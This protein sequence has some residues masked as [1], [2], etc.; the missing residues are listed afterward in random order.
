MGTDFGVLV[1]KEVNKNQQRSMD[2]IVFLGHNDKMDSSFAKNIYDILN[3]RATDVLTYEA[4]KR[5]IDRTDGEIISSGYG[6]T[7]NRNLKI[8]ISR[9]ASPTRK[10]IRNDHITSDSHNTEFICYDKKYLKEKELVDGDIYNVE[11]IQLLQDYL[12]GFKSEY[13]EHFKIEEERRAL[14][15]S[16][17]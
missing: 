12:K 6:I 8:S 4:I 10:L 13:P 11:M 15:K 17:H 1:K 5:I 16:N 3:R 7:I 9:P 2:G 14:I